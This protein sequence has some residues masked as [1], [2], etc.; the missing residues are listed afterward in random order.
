[1]G[2][3][4]SNVPP[5]ERA[6]AGSL[7]VLSSSTPLTNSVLCRAELQLSPRAPGGGGH[8]STQAGAGGVRESRRDQTRQSHPGG[9]GAGSTGQEVGCGRE[10][11][12]EGV[13][14]GAVLKKS[15][16]VWEVFGHNG[17]GRGSETSLKPQGGN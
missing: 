1:M 15:P 9:Q 7:G 12:R 4:H 11:V 5:G 17:G 8:R 16:E 6:E 14:G 3:S 13:P 10:A 2:T